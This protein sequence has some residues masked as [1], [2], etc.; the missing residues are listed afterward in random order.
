MSTRRSAKRAYLEEART[1]F[2]LP[3]AVPVVAVGDPFNRIRA[4]VERHRR[5]V[6]MLTAKATAALPLSRDSELARRLV[7]AGIGPV[8]VVPPAPTGGPTGPSVS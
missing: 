7:F 3:D 8:M 6:V 2:A 4:E 1:R 5:P